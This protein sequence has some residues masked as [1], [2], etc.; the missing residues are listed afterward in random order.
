MMTRKDHQKNITQATKRTFRPNRALWVIVRTRYF[1]SCA[2]QM[3]SRGE[4]NVLYSKCICSL[5]IY[6]DMVQRQLRMVTGYALDKQSSIPARKKSFFSYTNAFRWTRGVIQ[7][8]IQLVKEALS[9]GL[10]QLDIVADNSLL[11]TT[12]INNTWNC[13]PTF[14]SP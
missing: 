5:S 10:R 12:D 8:L 11:S 14:N 1:S 9:L 6:T 4:Q 13:G 7:H 3:W 2:H